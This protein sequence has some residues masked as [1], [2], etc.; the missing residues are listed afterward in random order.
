MLVTIIQTKFA[1]YSTNKLLPYLLVASNCTAPSVS[2]Q[3]IRHFKT[4]TTHIYPG[5]GID[6]HNDCAHVISVHADVYDTAG[7]IY[8][9]ARSSTGTR[10][11]TSRFIVV[12]S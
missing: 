2:V 7:T 9:I 4:C 8:N 1:V 11:T 12:P 10:S 3:L 6:L 5:T